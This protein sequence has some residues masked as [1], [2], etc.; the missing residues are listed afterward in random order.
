MTQ[1]LAHLKETPSQTAGPYIHIGAT[2]N[3]AE[4]VGV[5]PIDLGKSIVGPGAK[6][7]RV[8]IVGRVL[9]GAGQPLK[10]AL[11]EI[12]QADAAG[13]YNSPQEKRGEADPHF[14]G[15]GRQPTDGETG[16]FRFETI[17]PGSVPFVDRRP[18]APHVT[19]WIIARGINLGL[20]TRMY[21]P[22]EAAAN[23]KCPVLARLEPQS[24][25]KTLI[26][27]R[28][29]ERGDAIYRF[30]IRLQGEDETVFFDI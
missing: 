18:M 1:R 15:F 11:V 14:A 12:W 4:I 9:D 24:R 27:E 5:Y 3:H 29:E 30:D 10:D 2:P 8:T 6:G 23:A 25:I 16:E 22:D 26:A 28:D 13:L 7:E 21:F 19:F 17:K 20:H